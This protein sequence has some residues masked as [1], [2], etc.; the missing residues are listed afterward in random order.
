MRSGKA[1]FLTPAEANKLTLLA[2]RIRRGQMAM[3]WIQA[4]AGLQSPFARE[5][6]AVLLGRPVPSSRT[7]KHAQAT[8]RELKSWAESN[9]EGTV[10]H[11]M[12]RTQAGA[13]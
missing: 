2:S 4:S 5:V 13:L 8:A 12:L 7:R 11:G 6:A 10:R 3:P 1:A 9:G